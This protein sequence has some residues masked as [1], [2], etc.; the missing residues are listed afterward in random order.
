MKNKY[1]VIITGS[2]GML[3]KACLLESI[4]DDRIEKILLINRS[5]IDI[6]S[7]KIK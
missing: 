2:T 1:N 7:P 6:I 4:K 3:G 5:K